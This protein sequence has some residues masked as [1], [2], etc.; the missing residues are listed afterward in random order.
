MNLLS[1]LPANLSFKNTKLK[2][3]PL[4]LYDNLKFSNATEAAIPVTGRELSLQIKREAGFTIKIFKKEEEFDDAQETSWLSNEELQKIL[5]NHSF[6][7]YSI[8]GKVKSNGSLSVSDILGFDIGANQAVELSQLTTHNKEMTIDEALIT[9][10]TDYKNLLTQSG[11]SSFWDTLKPN[12]ALTYSLI[13]NLDFE[14]S[15]N[16]LKLLS[17]AFAPVFALTKSGPKVPLK[18]NPSAQI[19]FKA[20]KN[21]SFKILIAKKMDGN[22]RLSLNK[23]RQKE[24]TFHVSGE[25][26][27]HLPDADEEKISRIINTHFEEY[28]GK[29]LNRIEEVLR[30]AK[31]IRE[32]SF[33]IRLVERIAFEGDTLEQLTE[34]FHT[35][36][37]KIISA[38]QKVLDIVSASIK[39]GIEY[40]YRKLRENGVVLEAIVSKDILTS[41]LKNLVALNIDNLIA[42]AR[43]NEAGITIESYLQEKKL[44]IEERFAFGISVG[45]MA[46]KSAS[47]QIYQ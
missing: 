16:I 13:G 32:N 5:R 39:A 28:L 36:R 29:P 3:A 21:D 38:R 45:N 41:E 42:K 20:I 24:H 7:S 17:V 10:L 25:L 18:I 27:V 22:F 14:V 11:D 43:K 15:V 33:L 8:Y 34:H 9:D 4:L 46:L 44:T 31:E 19:R 35:Y 26:S 6:V 40:E 47:K 1:L 12:D 2:D 23:N 37:D 30:E